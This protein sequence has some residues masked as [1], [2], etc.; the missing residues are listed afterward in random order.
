MAW[1]IDP[2]I[3]HGYPW[4][5]SFPQSFRTDFIDNGDVRLPYYAWRIKEGVN[6]NYPWIYY[7][8]KEDT[9]T[10]GDMVI[11]GSQTNYPNGFS[12]ANRGGI[13][14]DF[15]NVDMRIGNT[16]GNYQL[17]FFK[18]KSLSDKGRKIHSADRKGYV[19]D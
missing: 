6:N 9:P 7:W 19:P 2:S 5:D 12:T 11:G 4:N 1:Y 10:G 3:N 14:N 8:F 15:D 13:K 16:G 17:A 18:R